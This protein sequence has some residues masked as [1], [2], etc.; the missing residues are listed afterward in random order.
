VRGRLSY[1]L[2]LS[3]TGHH[4]DQRDSFPFELVNLDSYWL[5]TARVGW[6]VNKSLEL[7]GR[8]HNAFDADYQDVVG[9]RTEGRTA[10]AGIRLA[11]GG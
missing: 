11:F 5:A 8:I 3:Y 4:L 6:R 9:Y 2:S 7:F 10:F 1:G